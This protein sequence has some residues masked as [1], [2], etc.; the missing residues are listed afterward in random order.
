MNNKAFV[1]FLATGQYIPTM[2]AFPPPPANGQMT[3][4]QKHDAKF[5]PHGFKDGDSC[6]YR[7]ARNL[8]KKSDEVD[9]LYG[10]LTEENPD[11]TRPQE[12]KKKDFENLDER[13]KAHNDPN[14]LPPDLRNPYVPKNGQIGMSS[15]AQK[16]A[17]EWDRQHKD[18]IDAYRKAQKTY[19]EDRERQ[20]EELL[21]E[22]ESK[23][24]KGGKS[25]IDKYLEAVNKNRSG[26]AAATKPSTPPPSHGSGNP[27]E[28]SAKGQSTPTGGDKPS[29]PPKPS[30]NTPN[31]LFQHYRDLEKSLREKGMTQMADD[32]LAVREDLSLLTRMQA[33]I[34][35]K[36]GGGE[37]ASLDKAM[38]G[39]APD[40]FNA[41]KKASEAV[42]NTSTEDL[43]AALKEG[44]ANNAANLDA[45]TRNLV[46]SLNANTPSISAGGNRDNVVK[47]LD[48][49]KA[50]I[51]SELLQNW[52]ITCELTRRASTKQQ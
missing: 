23:R 17:I 25:A 18:E 26:K 1:E 6:K 38:E 13:W 43:R 45:E 12:S 42:K 31:G 41:I 7:E 10:S 49:I 3:D 35:K 29:S 52:I 51:A 22:T 44:E 28:P 27:S 24:E 47:S 20:M 34:E 15:G 14:Y 48:S 21:K 9:N 5:H 50:R 32:T 33:D 30:L 4:L 40:L 19:F 16:K 36:M 8:M 2:D 11:F 37:N 46:S 39:L